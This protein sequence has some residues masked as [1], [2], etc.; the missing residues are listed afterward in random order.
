MKIKQGDVVQ[1]ISGS[2]NGKEGR[3]LKVLNSNNKVANLMPI[4]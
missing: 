4:S 2:Y 3:V 1:V